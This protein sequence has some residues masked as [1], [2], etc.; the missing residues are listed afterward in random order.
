MRHG[1]NN[2]GHVFQEFV[3]PS[4]NLR[5]TLVHINDFAFITKERWMIFF[6]VGVLIAIHYTFM[7]EVN[8]SV[9]FYEN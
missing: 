2:R 6:S 8:S 1:K 7:R 9:S 5:G 3:I 4:K